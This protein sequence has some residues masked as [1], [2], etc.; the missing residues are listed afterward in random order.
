ML[1][2]VCVCVCVCVWVSVSVW[3]QPWLWCGSPHAPSA[4]PVCGGYSSRWRCVWTGKTPQCHESTPEPENTQTH[5]IRVLSDH[6]T[7]E[8]SVCA[9]VQYVAT[10]LKLHCFLVLHVPV[11]HCVQTPHTADTGPAVVS[12]W[13]RS[14]EHDSLSVAAH[15]GCL[16]TTETQKTLTPQ[17]PK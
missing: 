6:M 1:F 2:C 11:W 5:R 16:N 14:G 13:S 4:V 10:L 17:T 9:L 3:G 12:S 8:S 7:T 15:W